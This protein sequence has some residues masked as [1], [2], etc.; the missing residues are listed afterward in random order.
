MDSSRAVLRALA[1][2]GPVTRPQLGTLLNLSKPT[3]SAAVV[4]LSALGLVAPRGMAKGPMGR[5]ATTYGL[6]SSAGYVI[7]L[8]VGAAQVRGVAHAL[9]GTQIATIESP[10]ELENWGL[11]SQIGPIIWATAR[12]LISIAA[13]EHGPLRSIAVAVPRIVAQRQLGLDS[14]AGPEA[15]LRELRQR[16]QAPIILENNV[17]CAAIAEMSY[18][19]ARGEETFA[20]L[21][22]G[23]R[24]G[25]G[26]IANGRLFRGN[27]AAGEIG[28]TPFPWSPTSK[29]YREGLEDFLGAAAFMARCTA[30]WPSDSGPPPTSA[31]EL[32]RLAEGG[33][34]YARAC[35]TSHAADI[36]RLVAGCIGMLDPGLVVLGGGIGQNPLI[37]DEVTR[38]ATEL[39]WPTRIAITPLAEN[40][41][42]L[43]AMKLAADYGLGLLLKEDRHPAVVLPPLP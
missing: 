29:P 26:I 18:G 40:G 24:I 22:I 6:G 37:I 8:D 11:A 23:V 9:D 3:M 25:L 28:R 1:L 31:K 43:G 20:Y 4:E 2:G 16:V 41:T 5:T 36:G 15:A 19:A 12:H 7:G 14:R 10:I 30:N 39:T 38:V 32:F 34:F 35:V 33:S 21:Q 13:G 17:N 42:V 27:G